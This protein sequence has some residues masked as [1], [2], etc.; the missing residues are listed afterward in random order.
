MAPSVLA[1][2]MG[3]TRG[4]ISKLAERLIAKRLVERRENPADKRGHSL[5]LSLASLLIAPLVIPIFVAST[6]GGAKIRPIKG[7]T[8]SR[9]RWPVRRRCMRLLRLPIAMMPIFLR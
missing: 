9:S 8:A 2:K 4:A 1:T 7:A 5:S 3:M 6:D